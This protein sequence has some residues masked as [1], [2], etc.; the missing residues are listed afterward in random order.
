MFEK[1]VGM[2]GGSPT[3]YRYLLNAEKLVEKRATQGKLELG[4]LSLGITCG[5]CVIMSALVAMV[6]LLPSMEISTFTFALLNITLSMFMAGLWTLPYFDILLNPI[7]YPV[8][9][10]TPVSSA[11]LFSRETNAGPD[12][13][14]DA[15]NQLESVTCHLWYLDSCK[16]DFSTPISFS[17]RL[18][19]CCLYIWLFRNW[20]DDSVCRVFDKTIHQKGSPEYCP[21]RSI[22]VTRAFPIIN[23]LI[24]TRSRNVQMGSEMVIHPSERLVCGCCLA[25]VRGARAT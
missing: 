25:G 20:Y 6:P 22:C 19:A 21:V 11:D 12:L 9:A 14:C 23:L 24:T 8:V 18:P 16:R 1:I 3:Q 17:F 5:F 13:R 15:V 2:L 7:N 10:H 4:N